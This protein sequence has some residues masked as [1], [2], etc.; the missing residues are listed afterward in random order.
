MYTCNV[1]VC[2]CICAC[3]STFLHVHVEAGEQAALRVIF[4]S[5]ETPLRRW[6]GCSRAWSASVGLDRQTEAPVTL[7]SH[8]SV[9]G[10]SVPH[11]TQCSHG[12]WGQPWDEM[13]SLLLEAV[14]REKECAWHERQKSE[15]KSGKRTPGP[16][17]L[18][19][20]QGT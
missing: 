1:Y 13:S 11:C 3:T 18:S 16:A 9:L 10:V 6:D 8:F 17:L 4:G 15:G 19:W 12:L 7:Q 5:P 14:R 2:V 20:H